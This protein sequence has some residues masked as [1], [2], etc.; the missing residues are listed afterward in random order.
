MIEKIND[1]FVNMDN[2]G[3]MIMLRRRDMNEH[4]MPTIHMSMRVIIVLIAS[5]NLLRYPQW[6]LIV[7][8]G[9]IASNSI[10][11][12]LAKNSLPVI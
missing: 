12:F 6:P 5:S 11:L 4:N 1:L 3:K 2:R 8:I 7:A 10:V 9:P